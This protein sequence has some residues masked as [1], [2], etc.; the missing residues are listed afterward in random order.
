[1]RFYLR[2]DDLT[3]FIDTSGHSLTYQRISPI[4]DCKS[5]LSRFYPIALQE[6]ITWAIMHTGEFNVYSCQLCNGLT[7]YNTFVFEFASDA[8]ALSFKL[9]WML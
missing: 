7:I 5:D 1:M 6:R 3:P 4:A 2:V 9:R 8:D